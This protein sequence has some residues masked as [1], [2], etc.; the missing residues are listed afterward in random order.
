MQRRER[1]QGVELGD[2]VVVDQGRLD[3]A[4]PSVHDAVP[5]G[6]SLLVPVHRPRLLTLDDVPLQARRARIDG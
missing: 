5:D 6:L 1:G 2:D 4:S 3:K